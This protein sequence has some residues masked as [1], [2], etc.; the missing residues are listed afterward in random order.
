MSVES[1]YVCVHICICSQKVRETKEDCKLV[2][3]ST[4]QY[5]KQANISYQDIRLFSLFKIEGVKHS[6]DSLTE[7]S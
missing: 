1:I 2:L 4:I 5:M 7:E 6:E 3:G